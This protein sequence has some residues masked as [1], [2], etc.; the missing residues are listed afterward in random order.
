MER[1]LAAKTANKGMLMARPSHVRRV[2]VNLPV[3]LLKEARRALKTRGTT[4]T[5]LAALQ[6]VADTTKRR[7]LSER[8]FGCLD[9][10]GMRR[11]RV[12]PAMKPAK[13]ASANREAARA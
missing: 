2:S 10:Q 6:Q 8:D 3:S 7:Q 4:D 13:A 1:T 11:R 12:G 5:V 9:V